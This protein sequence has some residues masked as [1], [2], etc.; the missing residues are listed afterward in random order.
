MMIKKNGYPKKNFLWFK[1][2]INFKTLNYFLNIKLFFWIKI[3][4]LNILLINN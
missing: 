4:K 3:D 2:K 1:N